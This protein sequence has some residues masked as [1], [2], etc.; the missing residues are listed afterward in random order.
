MA[1]RRWALGAFVFTV[2]LGI[3]LSVPAFVAACVCGDLAE[4]DVVFDGTVVDSPNEAFLFPELSPP[5]S[6]VYTFAV[7]SVIRG[8][9]LDG[10]V[11]SGQG[12][13]TRSF[14][15]G[16]TY[17]VHAQLSAPDQEASAPAD[18][19]LATGQCLAGELLEGPPPLN[20]AV[21]WARSVPG[22]LVLGIGLLMGI[23]LVGYLRFGR[24]SATLDRDQRRHG[25]NLGQP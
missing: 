12:D 21:D 19:R 4:G 24:P 10:R 6:G 25:G 9:A 13:C 5:S 8:N 17:R 7:S 2:L 23:G 1:I 14:E 11:F 18:A 15:V 3:T 22:A 16:A 20:R